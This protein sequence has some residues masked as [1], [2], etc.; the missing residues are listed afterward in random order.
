MT[1]FRINS[2]DDYERIEA[3]NISRLIPLISHSGKHCRYAMD[4]PSEPTPAM[5]L[6]TLTHSY[7]LTPEDLLREYVVAPEVDR[8]TKVGREKWEQVKADAAGR[9]IVT[10]DE[11]ARGRAM[12]AAVRSHPM[13]SQFGKCDAEVAVQWTN[14]P[15]GLACKALVDLDG[16]EWGFVADL[17]T[18]SDVRPEA[19]R[20]HAA[21]LLYH[22]RMSWYAAALD[23]Q[24]AYLIAVETNPPH[25]VVVYEYTWDVLA[26]AYAKCAEAL[27]LYAV[28]SRNGVWPG[29]TSQIVPLTVPA[30]A[31]GRDDAGTETADA[32]EI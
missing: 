5:R 11:D 32:L 9:T 3:V 19:F 26:T 13:W 15:T 7:I 8:R 20:S 1:K 21:R 23:V 16:S 4:N 25:D 29:I 27:A 6:G 18:A 22:V 12:R 14:E 10:Q 24:T 17:K 30:W 28:Y 31:L 2:R